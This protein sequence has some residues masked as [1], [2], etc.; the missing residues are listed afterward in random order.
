MPVEVVWPR[1]EIAKWTDSTQTWLRRF[2]VEFI[3][4]L[5]NEVVLATPFKTGHLRRSWWGSLNSATG[6]A[7]GGGDVGQMNAVAAEFTENDTYYG[8]NTA[9][10]A[11]FVE[12]GTYK[13]APRAFVRRT[14][15]RAQEI[16][17]RVGARLRNA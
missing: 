11:A 9:K 1:E 10:Y 14:V 13:M 3:Q 8:V 7:A 4:E 2:A 16:A 5:N 15:D 17:N 12:Y 6:G